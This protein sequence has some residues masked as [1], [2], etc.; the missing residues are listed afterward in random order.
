M[1]TD[2]STGRATDTPADRPGTG[3]VRKGLAWLAGAAA[4]AGGIGVY[5]LTSG[6]DYTGP[7]KVA[8]GDGGGLGD[9]LVD[10]QGYA[11]Y[12]FEPDEASSVTC[13]G[14]CAGKWPPLHAPAGAAPLAGEGVQED[15]LGR[16]S[17]DD[18]RPV[19]TYAGWPLYRYESD[20]PGE[21]SGHDVDENG[22]RWLAVTTDG[23]PAR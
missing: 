19:V 5:E 20:D 16:V 23:Q 22:G 13:T 6:P 7:A 3:R 15:L 8:V 10:G 14:S 4:L 18:G 12:M 1:S 2:N 21:V 17:D 9:V 11:L